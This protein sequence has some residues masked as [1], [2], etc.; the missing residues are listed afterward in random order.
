MY[1]NDNAHDATDQRMI[2]MACSQPVK[3]R[4]IV[5]IWV[6]LA[7]VPGLPPMH[8]WRILPKCHAFQLAP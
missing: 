4:H 3:V 6:H 7:R 8:V 1:E 5:Q 2:N